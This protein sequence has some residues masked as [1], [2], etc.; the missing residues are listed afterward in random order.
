M[1]IRWARRRFYRQLKWSENGQAKLEFG[2]VLC[3]QT[4]KTRNKQRNHMC[5]CNAMYLFES[6][7]FSALSR[8][9]QCNKID[10]I[11]WCARARS[12]THL[13]T[14]WITVCFMLL[15]TRLRYESLLSHKT[16]VSMLFSLVLLFS[17]PFIECTIYAHVRF[18]D[19][20]PLSMQFIKFI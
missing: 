13:P 12:H 5:F 16:S 4:K 11:V 10:T 8:L 9:N 18:F 14:G 20:L 6:A 1:Q 7:N 15:H 3:K 17:L 19:I 2:I